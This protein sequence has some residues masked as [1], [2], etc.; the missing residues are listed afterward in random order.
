[1][2][3][4][5]RTKCFSCIPYYSFLIPIIYCSSLSMSCNSIYSIHSTFYSSSLSSIISSLFLSLVLIL[6]FSFINITFI[7][8]TSFYSFS[9]IPFPFY[10]GASVMNL[11]L[12]ERSERIELAYCIGLDNGNIGFLL[13]IGILFPL[14]Y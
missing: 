8:A 12:N 9:L 6:S 11:N 13:L 4:Y 1:M 14:N 3:Y 5:T 10:C 2:N 7:I